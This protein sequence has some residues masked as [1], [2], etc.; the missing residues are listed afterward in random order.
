VLVVLVGLPAAGKS[1][2]TRERFPNHELV[3][4]DLWPNARNRE[5]R[6]QRLVEAALAAGRP[7]IVDNTN[8]SP[9]ERAPLL[10]IARKLGNAVDGYWFVPDVAGS[11]A[12][13][14]LREGRSRVPDVAI[15]A[16]RARLVEPTREEGFSRLFHVTLEPSGFVVIVAR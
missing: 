10:A 16:V 2:F 6:Q 7:V 5:R 3:S 13:N 14:A 9:E 12:R 8:P 15:R 1:T 11:F 4:K